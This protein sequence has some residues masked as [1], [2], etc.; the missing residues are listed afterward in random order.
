MCATVRS[1]LKRPWFVPL[2]D[3]KRLRPV[4]RVRYAEGDPWRCVRRIRQILSLVRNTL[5]VGKS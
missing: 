5:Q 3:T 2:Q 4:R 1:M